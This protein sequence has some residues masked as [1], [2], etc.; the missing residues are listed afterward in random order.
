MAQVRA[1]ISCQ[2]DC[3]AL[4]P[5]T[6]VVFEDVW[7]KPVAAGRPADAPFEYSYA[8]L[9]TP[10]PT[11]PECVAAWHSGAAL[12]FITNSTSIRCGA[13]RASPSTWTA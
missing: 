8:D 7:T 9:A 5:S 10:A 12:R 2:T 4:K 13:S 6:S 1:R 3:A 11:S